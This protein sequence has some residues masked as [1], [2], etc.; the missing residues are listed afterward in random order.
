VRREIYPNNVTGNNKE[1]QGRSKPVWG[2]KQLAHFYLDVATSQQKVSQ[3]TFRK[4]QLEHF[5]MSRRTLEQNQAQAEV[6]RERS[7]REKL[8][9]EKDLM[10][11]EMFNL[12]QQLQVSH[13]TLND[14]LQTC[15][16]VLSQ[17]LLRDVLSQGLSAL[18]LT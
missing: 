9:R 15:L 3:E 4:E 6:Q 18:Y 13:F 10:T 12:R 11:G 1:L 5:P 17:G 2:S 14:T 8:A 7:Q 16:N